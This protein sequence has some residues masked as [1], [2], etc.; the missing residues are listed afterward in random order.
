MESK[1]KWTQQQC[2]KNFLTQM[3]FGLEFDVL[4]WKVS[5]LMLWNL[6]K[7]SFCTINI[8]K[9]AGLLTRDRPGAYSGICPG[10]AYIFF[11]FQGGGSAPVGVWKPPEIN[12]F[13]WSRGGGLAPLAPHEYASGWDHNNDIKLIVNKINFLPKYEEKKDKKKRLNK[14]HS[15]RVY[16]CSWY[17]FYLDVLCCPLVYNIHNTYS[18]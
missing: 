11:S 1:V 12:R 13:H 10:G 2:K 7:K 14:S 17:W 6:S 15:V 5:S 8:R 18:I 3:D 16:P 9:Y 4:M